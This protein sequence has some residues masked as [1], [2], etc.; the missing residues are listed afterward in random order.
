MQEMWVQSLGQEDSL[1]KGVA[2]HSSILAWVIGW[3]EEPGELQSMVL[4]RVG[5]NWVTNT[6]THTHTHTHTMP[7]ILRN[8]NFQHH[9]YGFI[10]DVVLNRHK[11]KLVKEWMTQVTLSPSGRTCIL[12][13]LSITD[14]DVII[15]WLWE[16]MYVTN[17]TAVSI[18]QHIHISNHYVAYL[19]FTQC[20]MSSLFQ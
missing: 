18:L 14:S 6:H 2:T 10:P 11:I 3:I 20:Y 19:K 17:L 7:R 16:V 15:A 13:T 8:I 5:R 1:E 12:P 9:R 4:Q